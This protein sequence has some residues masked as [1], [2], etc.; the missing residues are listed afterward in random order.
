MKVIVYCKNDD[1]YSQMLKSLLDMNNIPFENREVSRDKKSFEE[2]VALSG[3][4]QTPVIVINDHA[5][6]GFD[7]EMIKKMIEQELKME[8]QKESHE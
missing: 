7:R 8:Q 4:Q 5:Y 2:M 3:Q 1:P 6:A